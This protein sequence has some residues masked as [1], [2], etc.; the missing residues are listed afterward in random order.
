VSLDPGQEQNKQMIG[1]YRLLGLLGEGGMGRV[2]RAEE[3]NTR[4]EVALKVLRAAAPSEYQYRFRREV[5]LLASLEHPGIAR[6]YAAGASEDGAPWLA[7]E[8]VRGTNLMV[9]A[10]QDSLEQRLRLVVDVCRAVHYAHSRGIVHRDLKP[11]NILV[12]ENGQAKVLDFGVAHVMHEDVTQMT[13]A[14][15]ILGTITYMSPEQLTG[16]A[17]VVDPRIDVY[18]LGVITYQMIAGKLPHPGLTGETTLISALRI[19][20]TESAVRLSKLVPESSGDL[21]TIVMKALEPDPARRYSSALE[22]A[23]DLER[24]LSLRPIEARPPT[25]GYTLK[26]FV[27]RHRAIA[28]AAAA[29]TMAMA[30]ATII[31]IHFAIQAR[32]RLSEREAVNGFLI[33]MLSAADPEQSLGEK[34]TVRDV[35]DVARSELDG[36]SE[37]LPVSVEIQLR[38]A[39]GK[40]YLGLGSRKQAEVQSARALQLGSHYYDPESADYFRLLLDNALAQS[41]GESIAHLKDV[42]RQLEGRSGPEFA[43]LE[44]EALAELGASEDE[45]GNQKEAGLLL[46]QAYDQSVLIFGATNEQT[47]KAGNWLGLSMFRQGDYKGA[48]DLLQKLEREAIHQFGTSP[49]IVQSIRMTQV[50]VLRDL[51]RPSEAEPIARQVLKERREVFGDDHLQTY[52]AE[53]ILSSILTQLK[54]YPEA[55]ELAKSATDG[56]ESQYGVDSEVYDSIAPIYGYALSESG[57]Y[58]AA[59]KVFQA[60]LDSARKRPEGITAKELPLMNNLAVAW[61]RDGHLVE[62]LKV[63]QDLLARS[64]ALLGADHLH[65]ALF[66]CNYGDTLLNLGRVSAAREQLSSCVKTLEAQLGPDHPMTQKNRERLDKALAASSGQLDPGAEREGSSV[67]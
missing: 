1:P 17:T 30:A 58:P 41:G 45:A 8:L 57:Q 19:V 62:A 51:G 37:P 31:S 67:P 27:R 14:G 56:V 52:S 13:V 32:D 20:T 42:R 28:A 54:S 35:L 15:Q 36:F 66:R 22:L 24:Y 12:D 23:S 60:L 61:S 7:M 65:T 11:T 21:E 55:V 4:R 34:L 3:I 18:A 50:Q 63:Q 38:R 9:H 47:L 26:L 25:L 49:P 48:L 33:N 16:A 6:V 2:Y 29:V 39:L 59:R 46:Q 43:K 10:D 64:V 44:A 40:A 53:A 5:E